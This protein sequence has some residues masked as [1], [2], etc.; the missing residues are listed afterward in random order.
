[1]K[2]INF[3]DSDD[4]V[5]CK[6]YKEDIYICAFS[7][8]RGVNLK[9]LIHNYGMDEDKEI[10]VSEIIKLEEF[11]DYDSAILYDTNIEDKKILC[12]KYKGYNTINC[13]AF[14]IDISLQN[15]KKEITS[16][17]K[18][19]KFNFK[20]YYS[21]EKGNCN[22]TEF[23]EEYLLCCGD[24]DFIKCERRDKDSFQM[25]N[26]FT[27][28][29]PGIIR[30]LTIENNGH[31]IIKLIYHNNQ[32][33]YK[34]NE[35]YIVP[36]E[37]INI[38]LDINPNLQEEEFDLNELFERRTNTNYYISFNNIFFDFGKMI[39]NKKDVKSVNTFEKLNPDE[40]SLSFIIKRIPE[41]NHYHIKYQI[42]IEETY[43]SI[44]EINLNIIN[45]CYD[46]C[47]ICSVESSASSNDEHNCIKCKDNYFPFGENG[48][49]CYTKKDVG[50]NYPKWYF[51]N[52]TN[53]FDECHKN[54]KECSGPTEHNCLKCADENFFIYN[55]TCINECPKGTFNSKNDNGFN[56]CEQCYENCETCKKKEHPIICNV[57]HVLIIK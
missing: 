44:C 51:N 53:F 3:E 12:A 6:S 21:Y 34:M 43:D 23:N 56:T 4:F 29:I 48:T 19:D 20:G 31:D 2:N 15:G 27:L 22:Y 28:N 38:D 14:Q 5:S 49:N 10:K 42:S 45:N 30:N 24:I 32:S 17:K 16:F 25:I 47:A 36:P 9:F 7:Q 50:I 46:S 39:L 11:T 40:N 57:P 18:D 26:N 41:N 13:V 54:C 52:D 35:Y 1:M 55:G 33:E 8:N 37:C